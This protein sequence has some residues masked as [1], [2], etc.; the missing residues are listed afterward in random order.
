MQERNYDG[1]EMG[2]RMRHHRMMYRH[3]GNRGGCCGMM[4]NRGCGREREMECC[5]RERE[6][7]QEKMESE[8]HEGKGKCEGES[9]ECP[10][11][12]DGVCKKDTIKK[13]K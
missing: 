11:K 6:G 4:M 12:K 13:K 10:M 5:G 1:C 7:C 2:G 9:E 8:C 3:G